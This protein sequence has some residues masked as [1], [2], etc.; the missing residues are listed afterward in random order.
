MLVQRTVFAAARR[1]AVT[2]TVS[3]SFSTSFVRR[4]FAS[5]EPEPQVDCFSGRGFGIS[6]PE[7]IAR[8]HL[9]IEDVR[10]ID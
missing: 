5:P 4:T 7:S 3:R 10:L 8:W 2:S 6:L 1:V 9:E